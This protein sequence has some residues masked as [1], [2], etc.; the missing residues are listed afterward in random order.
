MKVAKVALVTKLTEHF[1]CER[2]YECCFGD[3]EKNCQPKRDKQTY[4]PRSYNIEKCLD[5]GAAQFSEKQT[6]TEQNFCTAKRTHETKD[7][8]ADK[9]A[10]HA[11]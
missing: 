6:E 7:N 3:T 2:R 8:A 5:D 1:S 4:Q 9:C 11:F 10:S